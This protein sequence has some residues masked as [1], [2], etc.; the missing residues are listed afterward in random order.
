MQ[1]PLIETLLAK[2]SVFPQPDPS[3][4]LG[5]DTSHW[6]GVVDWNKA[7]A[8]GV[9][10]AIIKGIDG[11]DTVKYF[12]ENYTGAKA[13]GL[14]V[15]I[16]AWLYRTQ[17]ISTGAQARALAALAEKYPADFYVVDF[18]W[19]TWKGEQ[20]NPTAN[21]LY[22]F[23]IPFEQITGKKPWIYT[24]LGYWKEFGSTAAMWKD[25]PLWEA[26]YN[27]SAPSPVA[28]WGNYKAWQFT[29][30][31][32]GVKYGQVALS[33][34]L[35]YYNGTQADF[36]KEFGKMPIPVEAI[37]IVAVTDDAGIIVPERLHIFAAVNAQ[38]KEYIIDQTP[39]VPP[40]IDPPVTTPNL[41]RVASEKWPIT[42]APL[43]EP[44]GGGPLTQTLSHTPKQVYTETPLNQTWQNY[45]Q[46]WNDDRA[47]KKICAID[48]GPSKGI[49]N[50]GMLR[51]IGLV[52]PSNASQRNVVNVLEIQGTWARIESI[53]IDGTADLSKY[54]PVLTPWLFHKVCDNK[55]N[56]VIQ[57]IT[58]PILG[59]PWWVPLA[60]LVKA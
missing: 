2:M 57:N 12:I 60:A 24:A 36:D 23:A 39:T 13:A 44:P 30:N 41:Y 26:Q 29:P 55:G 54:S 53:P 50:N 6:T 11:T 22:G 33:A 1:K 32:D 18:E 59:G 58:C 5:I 7:K 31:G 21:D 38:P 10:F 28:P 49:N 25:Y 35:S 19:T 47:M 43:T 56:A 51:Y 34:D 40:I 16:Y 52:W 42:H 17:N 15:G 46:R 37:K 14:V 27:V 4:V 8:N 48:Y 45:I 20:A 3:R 9:Q